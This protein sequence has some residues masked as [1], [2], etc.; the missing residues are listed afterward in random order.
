M[1]IL[2]VDDAITFRKQ[3]KR[4]LDDIEGVEVVGTASNGKIAIDMIKQSD[5]D[6]ITLDLNM[7]VMGGLETIEKMREMGLKQDIIVFASKTARNTKDTLK[8]LSLGASDFIVKPDG[9]VSD[10]ETVLALVKA[11]LVPRIVQF[12]PKFNLKN[13]PRLDQ[14]VANSATGVALARL[15]ETTTPAISEIRSK[16]LDSF[17]PQA[18]VVASS[19]GGPTA[20]ETFF[21]KITEPPKVPILVA[22]HMPET[23]TKFLSKRIQNI[24]GIETREAR[25]GE[26]VSAGIIYFAPGNYHMKFAKSESG[27]VIILDQGPRVNSVRPAADLLF[28]SVAHIY[29]KQAMG[30]VLTGMGSDGCKGCEVIKSNGGHIMIQNEETST[31][32]G[33]PGEVYRHGHF[34][35]L[36]SLEDC[37]DVLLRMSMLRRAS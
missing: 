13:V 19:T 24:N 22:Q 31:V 18:I 34:D 17:L 23:F 4:L 35:A 21:S 16:Q 10:F 28:Q 32:W 9:D 1:K 2:V 5:V 25:N 20:L 12:L 36:G 26:R 29:G 27:T 33:M 11:E 6:L 37:R 3:I 14:S 15:S 7:P 8:A 30:F